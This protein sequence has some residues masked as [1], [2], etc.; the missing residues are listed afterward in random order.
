V[1]NIKNW[2]D[3]A[4]NPWSSKESI[5]GSSAALNELV[6]IGTGLSIVDGQW[7][8]EE[9]ADVTDEGGIS[10]FVVFL[11]VLVILGSLG[12]VG[13]CIFKKFNPDHPLSLS[14]HNDLFK[15]QSIV[16]KAES[17]DDAEPLKQAIE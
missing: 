3:V 15:H 14:I 13:L 11:I 16:N 10:G 17:V 5:K 2:K 4:T 1:D 8:I 6:L 9:K 7:V 12:G